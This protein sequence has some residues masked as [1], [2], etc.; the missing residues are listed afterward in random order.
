MFS[1]KDT[2]ST[3]HVDT[4]SPNSIEGVTMRI[5]DTSTSIDTYTC[6]SNWMSLYRHPKVSLLAEPRID[7]VILHTSVK[8]AIADPTSL[9]PTL[10]AMLLVTGQYPKITYA[11]Q[12]VAGFK[13][14]THQPLGAM[15]SLRGERMNGFLN[16]LVHVVL[17]RLP[18]WYGLSESAMDTHG[19]LH[20][21]ISYVLAFPELEPHFELFEKV[22][23]FH[24][25]IVT[26]TTNPQKALY[27]LTKVGLPVHSK[28]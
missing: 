7:R 26:N 20:F 3:I 28:G 14:R 6:S 24:V 9:F 8:T 23:G 11:K 19:G 17:P 2:K 12:S 18:D 1:S 15:V 22:Q 27:A 5:D 25:S 13:L 21:G 4:S 10:G 16:K